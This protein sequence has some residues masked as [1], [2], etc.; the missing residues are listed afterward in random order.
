MTLRSSGG[1]RPRSEIIRSPSREDSFC[2]ASCELIVFRSSAI[3]VDPIIANHTICHRTRRIHT[4]YPPCTAAVDYYPLSRPAR[5]LPL[6]SL[7][8]TAPRSDQS[9]F[10]T[11]SG[12]PDS[13]QR[14]APHIHCLGVFPK[15]NF[16]SSVRAWCFQVREVLW[17]SFRVLD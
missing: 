15:R 13:D 4:S 6:P 17:R 11:T 7:H 14:S 5:W 16:I 1:G 8:T 9:S 2:L 3:P 12:K 10:A